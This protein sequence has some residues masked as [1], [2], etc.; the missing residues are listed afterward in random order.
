LNCFP[1]AAD[2]NHVNEGNDTC[3]DT[4]VKSGVSFIRAYSVGSSAKLNVLVNIPS[5]EGKSTE[6]ESNN[7]NKKKDFSDA[8][9]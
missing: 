1:K 3:N 4:N 8:S 9:E 7:R 5:G 6:H 2:A